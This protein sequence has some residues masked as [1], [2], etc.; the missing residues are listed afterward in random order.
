MYKTETF[1]ENAGTGI[2]SSPASRAFFLKKA[3]RR[4]PF[5][6]SHFLARKRRRRPFEI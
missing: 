6:D 1:F 3:S 2:G 4:C 5:Q